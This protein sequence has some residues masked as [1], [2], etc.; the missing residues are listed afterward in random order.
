MSLTSELAQLQAD[1]A[2]LRRDMDQLLGYIRILENGVVIGKGET[3][4]HVL[5]SGIY[6]TGT[7]ARNPVTKDLL[8]GS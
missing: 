6:A 5:D 3:A 4:L 1:N 7:I 8:N 2:R